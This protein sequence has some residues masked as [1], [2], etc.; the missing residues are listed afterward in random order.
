MFVF[1]LRFKCP[2]NTLAHLRPYSVLSVRTISWPGTTPQETKLQ[3]VLTK[4]VHIIIDLKQYASQLTF[5][6]E[7]MTYPLYPQAVISASGI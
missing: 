1:L 2:I 4:K 6:F 5:D 7:E 3:V